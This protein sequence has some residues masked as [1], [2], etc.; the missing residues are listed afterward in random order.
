MG[1][2]VSVYAYADVPPPEHKIKAAFIYNFVRF[3]EWPTVT[4]GTPIHV[5]VVGTDGVVASV[6]EALDGR[7]V[8]DRPIIVTRVSSEEESKNSDVLYVSG[9]NPTAAKRF[10]SAAQGRPVLTIT[11][12]DRFLTVGSLVNFFFADDTVHFA[13][14]AAELEHAPIKV[15]SQMLQFAAMVRPEKP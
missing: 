9:N 13:V 10:V 6:R 5:G 2:A 15:S 11:E 1:V 14:N 3:V 12:C 7:S 4:A 8:G